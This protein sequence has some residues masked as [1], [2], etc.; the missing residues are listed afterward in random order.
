MTKP[1]IIGKYG[2][3]AMSTDFTIKMSPDRK[4]RAS[5]MCSNTHARFFTRPGYTQQPFNRVE[6]S[7]NSCEWSM[8]IDY[9][10]NAQEI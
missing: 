2:D 3:H 9:L 5:S 8:Q 4:R 7:T 10:S 1:E 6:L